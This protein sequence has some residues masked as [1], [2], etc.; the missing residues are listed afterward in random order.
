MGPY[1]IIYGLYMAIYFYIVPIKRARGVLVSRMTLPAS[2]HKL[3]RWPWKTPRVLTK[4]T[5]YGDVQLG[6][7]SAHSRSQNRETRNTHT[8]T[9]TGTQTFFEKSPAGA[10]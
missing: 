5:T 4:C 6:Q 2:V 7:C 10:S 3:S 8:H 1:M 9:H